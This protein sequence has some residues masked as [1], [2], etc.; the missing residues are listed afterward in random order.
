MFQIKILFYK[1]VLLLTRVVMMILPEFKP[2]V[3]S[4]PGSAQNL[5]E[6]IAHFGSKKIM[7]VT[8]AMLVE[9]GMIEPI[10][11]SLKDQGI[12]VVVFSGVEPDP[13]FAVV[14]KG[15]SELKASGCDSVLA[16]GGGSSIDTA[17]VMAL[18]AAN[19]KTPE[20]LVGMFK[21]KVPA[22][23]L[24][25]IPTTAGTGSEVTIGAVIS[26][27]IANE[28]CLV[29]DAKVVP[30]AVA[31]DASLMQGMPPHITAATGM[32]ALTHAVESY[33]STFNDANANAYSFNASR[34]VMNNLTKVYDDGSNL[35]ARNA[36]A[37]ASYYGGLG[38]SKSFLGY[39]HSIAH[40]F[41][42]LYHTP[43]GLA[44]AIIL[45]HILDY[46]KPVIVSK[47][48]ALSV[49]AGLG[50]ASESDWELADKFIARIR[51]MNAYMK[52][53]TTLDALKAEDI[54]GMAKVA[55]KEAHYTY[56]VPRYMDQAECERII[57]K[58]LPE[59]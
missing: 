28:K 30:I 12:E 59:V 21:G 56:P 18:A 15:L 5:I 53:P 10:E 9:L 40:Q 38:L 26:D 37:L 33:V 17:K 27:T 58:M 44:N 25:A 50:K 11:T 8:D 54:P 1:L 19:N 41:G 13:N 45:P 2:T 55:L 6:T 20:D 51:E 16:I 23:A 22:L 34:M 42:A 29:V 31:L 39:V 14:N 46:S 35:E 43:H 47:L 4:G 48:A 57:A 7:I 52:I 3:F 36:M 49:D 32:D 24:Y